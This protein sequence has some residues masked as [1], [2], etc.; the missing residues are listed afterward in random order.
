MDIRKIEYFLKVAETKNF[1]AAAKEL[2]ISH[3]ALSKQIQSLEAEIDAKLLE[4]STTRVI[5]TEIG[6]KVEELYRPVLREWEQAENQ[7]R[8]FINVR[9]NTLRIGYFNGNSY[10][11]VMEPILEHLTNQNPQLK[12]SLLAT[13]LD[14][15]RELMNTDAIDLAI[16]NGIHKKEW[17]D[18]ETIVLRTDPLSIIVSEQHPWYGR[19]KVSKEELKEADFLV[20]ANGRPLE[21]KD[22]FFGELPVRSRETTYN[23]D[24]YM[25]TLKRGKHFGIIGPTY[26]RREGNYCLIELPEAYKK[27]H[28]I[29]AMYKTLHPQRKLLRS[30]EKVTLL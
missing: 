8:A 12:Y 15:L 13:D 3:Q 20:Y 25:G 17:T 4:R 26:S 7:L 21:G 28:S 27:T 2:H 24:T 23:L 6:K 1:N 18:V 5:V 30:L 10:S 14:M 11:R 19:E 29:M 16:T 22:A 9:N